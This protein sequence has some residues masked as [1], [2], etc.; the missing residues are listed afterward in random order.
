MPRKLLVLGDNLASL[1]ATCLQHLD[2]Q[3]SYEQR[4]WDD[5]CLDAL[6]VSDA[7]VIL[8]N[9][10]PNVEKTLFFF[11]WLR[12]NPISIPTLAILP[13]STD[14][15]LCD[16]VSE[17][18][19][20]F[21]LWPTRREELILRIA[22]LL[23][24]EPSVQLRH[25]LGSEIGLKELV[26]THQLF[27]RAVEQVQLFASSSA[28]VLITGETGT[29]KEMFAHAIHSL[30]IRKNGPFIPVDCAGFPEQLADNELYGHKRGAFT[31]A[32]N[33]QR[34][35]VAAAEGGTLFLDEIDALSLISQ[36]KLLRL[37]Q[38]ST[39]RSLGSN[40]F[41]S[42]NVRIIAATNQRI[43]ELV[44]QGLFRSDLYFRLNVLRLQLPR[45]S[46]RVADVS[47]LARY[48]L[49]NECIT[50]SCDRKTF[51]T[52]ALRKLECYH[53][54]GNVRELLNA[55]QRASVC[56]RGPHILPHHISLGCDEPEVGSYHGK[57]FQS[58]KRSAVEHFE[59]AYLEELL[60]RHQG[61]VTQAARE[62]GKERRA[63]GRLIKKYNFKFSDDDRK[64]K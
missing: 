38:E 54:P 27:L 33:D 4:P 13:D 34:G 17:R 8:A 24:P 40:R 28:P 44:R 57:R 25:V 29:G 35:L 58:A 9:T 23:G 61:N 14:R 16:R 51:S 20:D 42:A 2:M 19:D 59:R 47:L 41:A 52:A 49:D 6:R 64:C 60:M 36:P 3:L 56:S 55:V 21:V 5:L 63:L 7:Q 43:E 26:G 50:G 10:V 46:E 37:L 62:A 22:R 12:N 30:S 31:S 32:H 15:Q 18:T 1:E 11:E 45:L 53:W 39:Y 48:F